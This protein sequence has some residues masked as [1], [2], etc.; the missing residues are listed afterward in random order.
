MSKGVLEAKT[1]DFAVKIVQFAYKIQKEKK[2]YVLSKQVLRSGTNP[3][4]MVSEA[5]YAQSKSDFIHK[6]SIGIKEANE[7]RYWLRLLTSAGIVSKEETRQLLADIN[8]I[9]RLLTASI[10]TAKKNNRT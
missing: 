4:A 1:Y 6:L 8:E 10:K 9:L 3:G 2:E 5:N 7:T